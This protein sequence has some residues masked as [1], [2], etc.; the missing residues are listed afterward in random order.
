[1]SICEIDLVI[2]F[3]YSNVVVHEPVVTVVP[4]II[5]NRVAPRRELR[6]RGVSYIFMCH[7]LEGE[8][9]IVRKKILDLSNGYKFQNMKILVLIFVG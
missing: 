8:H 2:L 7:E 9:S 5:D 1:L 3:Y 6:V 4:L